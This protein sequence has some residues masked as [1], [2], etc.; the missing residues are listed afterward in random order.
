MIDFTCPSFK[1]E[2]VFSVIYVVWS[3]R[4]AGSRGPRKR[5]AA[6]HVSNMIENFGVV[7]LQIFPAH[8]L[9]SWRL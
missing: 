1:L 7:V 5:T 2:V 6:S 9:E 3:S 8:E 4:R